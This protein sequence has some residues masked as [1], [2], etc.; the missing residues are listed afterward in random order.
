MRL[1]CVRTKAE[2]FSIPG[3]T[4]FLK[5][6]SDLPVVPSCRRLRHKLRLR[7]KQISSQ[8]VG[9]AKR[10]RAHHHEA[11]SVMDGGHGASAPLPTLRTSPRVDARP[12]L[13]RTRFRFRHRAQAG[14]DPLPRV[15][16]IDHF[17]D[18]Q[19]RGDRD[20]LAVGVELVDL[21]LVVFL[22]FHRVLDRFHLLAEATV[23][24]EAWKPPPIMDCAPRP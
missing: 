1:I 15:G 22:A 20:R 3:L 6:R 2:Y 8:S 11:C 17:V 16:G 14:H 10:K 24:N 18:L 23:K 9:W 13:C 7:A 21:G 12:L 19:H 4:L 5:I